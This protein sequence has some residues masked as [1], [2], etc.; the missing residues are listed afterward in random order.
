MPDAHPEKQNQQQ[1]NAQRPK[2]IP[3]ITYPEKQHQQEEYKQ[4]PK[5][6]PRKLR[7]C[8][9]LRPKP[10]RACRRRQNRRR[11]IKPS[12]P[13]TNH[14]SGS[15]PPYSPVPEANSLEIQNLPNPSTLDLRSL[16]N[17]EPSFRFGPSGSSEIQEFP[18]QLPIGSAI[19]PE[20]QENLLPVGL[21]PPAG[22]EY[23]SDE[24]YVTG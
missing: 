5:P 19:S 10:R 12:K 20:I 8:R 21:A 11:Y 16:T 9:G 17:D 4:R 15:E 2:Y 22:V 23:E 6:R 7:P 14:P 3:S 13:N 1:E 18:N 24:D